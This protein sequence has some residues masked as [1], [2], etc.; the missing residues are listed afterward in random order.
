[1]HRA[2]TCLFAVAPIAMGCEGARTRTETASST[3]DQVD[4]S[5]MA[6]S[7]DGSAGPPADAAPLDQ[8]TTTVGC[9]NEFCDDGETIAG[10]PTDCTHTAS[11]CGGGECDPWEDATSCSSD[12]P[13]PVDG[14]V[15]PCA[16]DVNTCLDD[17][18]DGTNEPACYFHLPG[19]PCWTASSYG[20]SGEPGRCGPVA[21]GLACQG[22]AS[23]PSQLDPQLA[24]SAGS[25]MGKYWCSL[26]P[27]VKP[28]ATISPL[29]YCQTQ[30]SRWAYYCCPPGQV[31]T[32]NCDSTQPK[33]VAVKFASEPQIEAAQPGSLAAAS[34]ASQFWHQCTDFFKDTQFS[35]AVRATICTGAAMKGVGGVGCWWIDT[36]IKYLSGIENRST[37]Q[38]QLLEALLA[39]YA[40]ICVASN[41]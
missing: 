18:D 20:A 4:G 33:C 34:F 17:L 40:A 11:S 14:Y 12:C 3:V 26:S 27:N 5:V 38:K 41:N 9:P 21:D 39:V 35:A 30:N 6:G 36:K 16:A 22:S 19:D 10:C 31:G 29:Q 15:D 2:L 7:L 25:G 24:D 32:F 13:A 28:G 1:M 8:T 37:A 23:N